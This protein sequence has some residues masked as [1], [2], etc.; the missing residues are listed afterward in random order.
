MGNRRF[1]RLTNAFSKK[2]DNHIYMLAL[3]FLHYNFCR[4][5]K[6][7]RMSPAMAA[8]IDTQLHDMEWIVGL[9]DAVAPKPAPRGPYKVAKGTTDVLNTT[10][11]LEQ[12]D[13]RNAVQ[14]R[15]DKP[16]SK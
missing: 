1:T 4:V 15:R 11:T 2:I 5:H 14:A 13:F 3:Y 10:V 16:N 8:G 9:M 7:L 12:A 6:T